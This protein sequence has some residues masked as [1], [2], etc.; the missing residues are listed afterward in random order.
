M[1]RAKKSNS[2]TGLQT[3][4]RRLQRFI[5]LTF[6]VIE[7]GVAVQHSATPVHSSISRAVVHGRER[8]QVAKVAPAAQELAFASRV[9]G[10]LFVTARQ[11]HRQRQ[12]DI[13][14]DRQVDTDRQ[15]DKQ[16]ARQNRQA[17]RQTGMNSETVPRQTRGLHH[18]SSSL[19]Q[20][21]M[22]SRQPEGTKRN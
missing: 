15:A 1:N 12:A 8:A 6:E 3:N 2:L 19:C 13:Q 20:A 21:D 17:D 9:G 11:T 10:H 7:F 4:T 5:L 22:C 14:T 18:M 16:T